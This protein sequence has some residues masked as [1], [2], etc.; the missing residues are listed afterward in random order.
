MAVRLYG[1]ASG[2]SVFDLYWCKIFGDCPQ[3][4]ARSECIG[5][6][7]RCQFEDVFDSLA[8]SQE[9]KAFIL[10]LVVPSPAVGAFSG[11]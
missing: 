9:C 10:V 1:H 6:W 5:D 7:F 11:G 4:I 8:Q 3:P 2:A